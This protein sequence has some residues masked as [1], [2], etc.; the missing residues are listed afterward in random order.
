M[1]NS[2]NQISW[3]AVTNAVIYKIEIK[4]TATQESTEVETTATQLSLLGLPAGSYSITVTAM[5]ASGS[6][7]IIMED[8][9][10][11]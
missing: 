6:S 7:S 2:T 1:A 9:V 10:A 3:N 4:N 11:V 5:L 8:I